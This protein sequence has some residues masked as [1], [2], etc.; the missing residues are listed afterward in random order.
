M[1]A[2][3]EFKRGR[4]RPSRISKQAILNAVLR[5]GADPT[6]AAIADRLGVTPPALY[7]HVKNH[8]A[9][10]EALYHEIMNRFEGPAPSGKTWKEFALALGLY[11]YKL[12]SAVPGLAEYSLNTAGPAPVVYKRQE[13]FLELAVADGMDPLQAF[14]A[15]RAIADFVQGWVAREHRRQLDQDHLDPYG[16]ERFSLL[17]KEMR[18]KLPLTAQA[19]SMQDETSRSRFEFSLGALVSGLA[20]QSAEPE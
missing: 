9:L 4:G 11:M 14:W 7:H 8:A 3:N 1:A 13:R 15:A 16:K 10:I 19:L 6:L 20:Q 17:S 12:Y 2:D 5:D 18:N